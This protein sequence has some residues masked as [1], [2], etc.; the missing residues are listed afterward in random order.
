MIIENIRI[1]ENNG[2]MDFI[3]GLLSMVSAKK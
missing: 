2:L 3:G 1:M